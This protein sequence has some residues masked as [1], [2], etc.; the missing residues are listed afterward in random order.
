MIDA[1][2]AVLEKSPQ[3][4][5]L[6]SRA[7][8]TKVV[9]NAMIKRVNFL[10]AAMLTFVVQPAHGAVLS[11]CGLDALE[12]NRAH[13]YCLGAD[14]AEDIIS[15]ANHESQRSHP[16]LT[17]QILERCTSFSKNC[18]EEQG[19]WMIQHE[20]SQ[21]Y[22]AF[23]VKIEPH[24][25]G[26]EDWAMEL[27]ALIYAEQGRFT[28]AEEILEKQLSLS[29]IDHVFSLVHVWKLQEKFEDSYKLLN[30][31]IET[32]SSQKAIIE[33]GQFYHFGWFVD[34][35]FERALA[36]YISVSADGLQRERDFLMGGIFLEQSKFE[37][38]I[39]Y[40][41]R[42]SELGLAQA[43]ELLGNLYFIGEGVQQDYARAI[44]YYKR[45]AS[46][47]QNGAFYMQGV[48]YLQL[49]EQLKG[50]IGLIA[51]ALIDED[52]RAIQVF[53]ESSVDYKAYAC[54]LY[55]LLSSPDNFLTEG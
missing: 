5:F 46:L 2:N 30:A 39:S 54:D 36:L 27:S 38:A 53:N 23:L 55:E 47:G 29:Q 40:L 11:S 45:A 14:S 24:V 4:G 25:E 33:L 6:G 34:V 42:S 10:F 52:Q 17:F 32:T 50:R 9:G 28:L 41:T 35:D 19:K 7:F 26:G 3:A 43:S 15:C 12:L 37:E 20:M 21:H 31:T 18:M 16:D 48:S 22:D 1:I 8:S 49:G 51:A 13:D 44:D